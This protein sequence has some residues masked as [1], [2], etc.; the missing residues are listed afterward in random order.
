M[1]TKIKNIIEQW[2][3]RCY[4]N[5]IPDEAPI[6]LEE[7]NKVISYRKLCLC[8]FKNDNCLKTIGFEPK[9]AEIYHEFKKIQLGIKERQLKLKL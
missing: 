2:E 4:K 5:G 3:K 8:I 6:R 9:K 7:L 1:E